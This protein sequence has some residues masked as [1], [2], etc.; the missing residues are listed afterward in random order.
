MGADNVVITTNN[1]NT[2]ITK[3]KTFIWKHWNRSHQNFW[4]WGLLIWVRGGC[5]R[6]FFY[7]K[8]GAGAMNEE[9]RV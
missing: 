2:I 9:R 1:K 4:S 3:K 7:F 8:G 5:G 6:P